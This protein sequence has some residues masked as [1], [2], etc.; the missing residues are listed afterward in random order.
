MSD[1]DDIARMIF[2]SNGATEEETE[3]LVSAETADDFIRALNK[4]A[5]REAGE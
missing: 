4:A 3:E 1:K 2:L 5:A